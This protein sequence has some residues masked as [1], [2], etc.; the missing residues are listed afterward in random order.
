MAR[1]GIK[2]LIPTKEI[3]S[4]IES[5]ALVEDST[6]LERTASTGVKAN[7]VLDTKFGSSATGESS[8]NHI[9]YEDG[10]PPWKTNLPIST[11]TSLD[12]VLSYDCVQYHDASSMMPLL[13][14]CRIQVRE[15]IR[16]ATPLAKLAGVLATQQRDKTDLLAGVGS[17]L[18]SSIFPICSFQALSPNK[19]NV[20][21]PG[22]GDD[23][24]EKENDPP[25]SILS[26]TILVNDQVARIGE[27]IKAQ[28]EAWLTNE[29]RHQM[30]ISEYLVKDQIPNWP[31]NTSCL[32]SLTRQIQFPTPAEVRGTPI[33]RT[34]RK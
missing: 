33:L 2:D 6:G 31:D 21:F 28:L 14:I 1:S 27:N 11:T 3:I 25:F 4:I 23:E 13:G 24:D 16:S 12:I 10:T 29:S 22:T 9:L 8:L 5:A 34:T 30:P 32:C 15:Q 17:H 20:G 19:R 7:N 18:K 26:A